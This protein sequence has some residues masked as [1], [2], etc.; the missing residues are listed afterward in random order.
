[1]IRLIDRRCNGGCR[2]TASVPVFDVAITVLRVEY[3]VHHNWQVVEF[4]KHER[5]ILRPLSGIVKF[6]ASR[7]P[8][9]ETKCV[10]RSV[11]S[12]SQQ[13]FAA[14]PKEP[15]SSHNVVAT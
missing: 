10:R 6:L 2:D 3:Y 15:S 9:R 8:N 11:F 4:E 13:G 14:C 1:M 5:L 7:T 12:S